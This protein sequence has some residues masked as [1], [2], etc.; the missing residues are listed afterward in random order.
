MSRQS[1]LYFDPATLTVPIAVAGEVLAGVPESAQ[2]ALWKAL[3]LVFERWKK[4][5]GEAPQYETDLLG[6]KIAL[7]T[8]PPHICAGPGVENRIDLAFK[9]WAEE[10]P[11]FLKVIQRAG[12]ERVFAL[13]IIREK[14]PAIAAESI[15]LAHNVLYA[16]RRPPT[17]EMIE[18]EVHRRRASLGGQKNAKL[19]KAKNA[20]RNS[21]IL[22]AQRQGT[23]V[24]SLSQRFKLSERQIRRIFSDMR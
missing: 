10:F 5:Y 3:N 24:P 12:I 22:R 2:D 13:L 21:Q 4:K 6:N 7:K 1:P 11:A 23:D 20:A 8:S 17:R 16:L 19:A 18:R 15:H 9:L 14:N